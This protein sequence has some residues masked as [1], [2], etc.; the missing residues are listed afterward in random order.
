MYSIQLSYGC[1]LCLKR[2]KEYKAR[3]EW[4]QASIFWRK[5][6]D[7]SGLFGLASVVAAA[8]AGNQ[9]GACDFKADGTQASSRRISIDRAIDDRIERS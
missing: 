7:S 6:S 4:C 2:K 8:R 9:T 3:L 1:A 5:K